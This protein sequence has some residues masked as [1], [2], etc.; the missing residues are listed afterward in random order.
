LV[1]ELK[2]KLVDLE[3]KLDFYYKYNNKIISNNSIDSSII[4]N[5]NNINS[6]LFLLDKNIINNGQFCKKTKNKHIEY[7]F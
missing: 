2:N 4:N 7:E 6:L 1:S 3:N 5:I